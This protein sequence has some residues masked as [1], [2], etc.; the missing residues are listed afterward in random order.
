[1]SIFRFFGGPTGRNAPDPIIRVEFINAA[2]KSLIAKSEMPASRLP[3]TFAIDT[4]LDIKD[5]KWS[6]AG[7]EPLAKTEFVKTGKLRLMLCRVTIGIPGDILFSLPTISDDIG[8]PEGQALP[9]DSIFGLHEDD[10]RQ[11]EFV[12]ETFAM[13]ISEELSDVQEIWKN[14]KTGL[15]FRK[16]HVRKR[17][18]DPMAGSSLSLADLK[19]L[20]PPVKNY[21]GVGFR[22]TRGI[23]AHSFAWAV[24][25]TL[26]IWGVCDEL[27]NITRLCLSGSPESKDTLAISDTFSVLTKQHRL[28]LVDW[29]RMVEIHSEAEAFK[30]YFDRQK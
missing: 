10:W 30:K 6:V 21:N 11:V 4:I 18:P 29:C 22:R 7:A 23:V 19:R 16:V 20:V 12:S 27:E 17:I 15:A 24:D 2:D 9:S 13:Q 8:K 14:Q 28:H 26:T 1:M 25:R 3:D 5:Q